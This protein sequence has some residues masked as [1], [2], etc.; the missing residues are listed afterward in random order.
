MEYRPELTRSG[1]GWTV[2]LL[3]KESLKKQVLGSLRCSNGNQ[4]TRIEIVT[5][6][7]FDYNDFLRKVF[8][9]CSPAELLRI[10]CEAGIQQDAPF[11]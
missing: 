11:A 6:A 8:T 1:D 4:V 5:A 9:D 3:T 2:Y 7:K 10:L